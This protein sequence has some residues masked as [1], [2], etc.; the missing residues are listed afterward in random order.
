MKTQPVLAKRW[1]ILND[2]PMSYRVNVDAAPPGATPLVHIHGFAISG[3]YLVPTAAQ[4]AVHY[5]TYVPDLP[6]YGRSHK[7]G[8]TLTIPEL[9][10]ALADFLDAVGVEKAVLLGN[11][12]GCLI[13][14]EFAHKYPERIERAVL[15]SPAGGPHNQPLARALPQLALDSVREPPR[16]YITAVPDYLRFG[17]LNTLRLFRAMTRFPT[18][19]R[20]VHL[21]VPTLIVVGVRDPLVSHDRIRGAANLPKNITM[22]LHNGAAHAINYSHPVELASVVHAFLEDRPLLED[23]PATGDVV[24][25]HAG[26][27]KDGQ[28]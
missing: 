9:A 17:V 22:V 23:L 12:M 15:V 8:R 19:D 16:M 26:E 25:V 4:L 5:P 21:T 3:S 1:M 7:P 24:I 6:G 27:T 11:S 20:F 18:I 13:T 2:L 28:P 10:D 14:I